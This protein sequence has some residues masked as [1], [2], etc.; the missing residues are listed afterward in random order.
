MVADLNAHVAHGVWRLHAKFL[1]SSVCFVAALGTLALLSA[2]SA[3]AAYRVSI[4][5][6]AS[7]RTLAEANA[8]IVRFKDVPDLSSTEVS[9]LAAEAPTQLKELFAVEGYFNPVILV[10]VKDGA[11]GVSEIRIKVDAGPRTKVVSVSITTAG[12]LTQGEDAAQR[13]AKLRRDW[14]LVENEFFSERGWSDAKAGTLAALWADRFP[15]ARFSSSEARVDAD[16]NT[17]EISIAIESGPSFRLGPLAV[18]GLARIPQSAV[19]NLS[20]LRPGQPYSQRALLDYQERLLASGLFDAA[21]VEIDT[22]NTDP[23]SATVLVNVRERARHS[24]TLGVGYSTLVGPRVS[25]EYKNL[26]VFDFDWQAAVTTKLAR[27]DRSFSIDLLSYPLPDLYRNMASASLARI[28][29]SGVQIIQQQVRAGRRRDSDTLSRRYFMAALREQ[30]TTPVGNSIQSAATA[31]YEMRWARVDNPVFPTDGY[32]LSGAAAYGLT[33][34]PDEKGRSFARLT[35]KAS[36]FK[37]FADGWLLQGRTEVGQVVARDSTGI[38]QTLLFRTGGPDTVRGY[39]HQSIGVR[40]S[41]PNSSDTYSLGGRFLATASVEVM[42]EVIPN[43]YGAVFVDAGDAAE[44]VQDWSAKMGYGIGARWRS[45]V[46]PVRVDLSYGQATRK[47][48]LDVSVG[49]TF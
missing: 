32:A 22:A 26:R 46:G 9:R 40:Q 2:G 8:D 4:D 18:T 20:T 11:D 44:R 45:P 27:D 47:V 16:A 34:G 3:Q 24:L 10:D 12:E 7:L 14:S 15:R 6:P 36:A 5:A 33:L 28:D 49:V 38:P 31:N 21:S 13:M 48:R 41:I 35:G 23:S 25:A 43:W 42:R 39:S 29:V 37:S 19:V 17:V 1:R 30:L